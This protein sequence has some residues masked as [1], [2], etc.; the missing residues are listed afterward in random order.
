M[1]SMF[2]P[3]SSSSTVRPRSVSSLAAHPPEIPDPT[4][5]ASYVGTFTCTP[6]A[7][8]VLWLKSYLPQRHSVVTFETRRCDT[9]A[10]IDVLTPGIPS[11]ASQ[12]DG[13]VTLPIPYPPL[14]CLAS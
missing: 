2:L 14:G 3:R 5:M 4:T 8:R 7:S 13:T 1:C 12:N 11:L 6:L 9:T 10:T